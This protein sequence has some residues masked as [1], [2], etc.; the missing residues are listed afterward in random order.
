MMKIFR[1]AAALLLTSGT[2]GFYAAAEA[3]TPVTTNS[4]KAFP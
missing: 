3:K 4:S 1:Q 2:G